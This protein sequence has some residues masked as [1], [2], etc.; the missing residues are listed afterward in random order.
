VYCVNVCCNWRKCGRTRRQCPKGSSRCC[1][2]RQSTFPRVT[3]QWLRGGCRSF[4]GCEGEPWDG[5]SCHNAEL[6]VWETDTLVC[7]SKSPP[8][9]SKMTVHDASCCQESSSSNYDC[10][11]H[12]F[13]LTRGKQVTG[14]PAEP[15]GGFQLTQQA[16]FMTRLGD[17]LATGRG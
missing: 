14:R 2:M 1:A 12:M 17:P 10:S 5:F 8:V 15:S 3:I 4:S 7:I 11:L 6:P 16:R 13:T 9:A